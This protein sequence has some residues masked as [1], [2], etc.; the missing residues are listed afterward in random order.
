VYIGQSKDIEQRFKYY[1]NGSAKT[2]KRIYRS[3]EK[4]GVDK[5]KF[6][7]LHRCKENELD[8]LE[9]YY[10][11]LFSAFN[12]RFDLNI[13]DGGGSRGKFSEESKKKLS[14][15][16]KAL[17][18]RHGD[19]YRR[20]MSKRL[21]GKNN[22]M[23]GKTKEE[24]PNWNKKH[25]PSTIEKMKEN[26]W[27]KSES[28]RSPNLG[29]PNTEEQKEKARQTKRKR[30]IDRYGV[31]KFTYNNKEYVCATPIE[32]AEVLNINSCTIYRHTRRTQDKEEFNLFGVK[33]VRTKEKSITSKV[34]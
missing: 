13:R 28:F 3:L 1:K 16:K 24:S 7:I 19:E 6:E 4:Y 26:H 30:Y 23:Y 12:N 25:K 8:Q 34:D 29:I 20:E 14:E 2:Q 17:K 18:I 33:I 31:Y 32:V 5:H 21:S 15:T 27:S 22:P 11:D 10:V 9:K